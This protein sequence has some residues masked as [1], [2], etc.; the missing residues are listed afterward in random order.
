MLMMK[1][2]KNFK[3]Q[4]LPKITSINEADFVGSIAQ[5]LEHQTLSG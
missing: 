3:A 4:E 5:W 1:K 2:L